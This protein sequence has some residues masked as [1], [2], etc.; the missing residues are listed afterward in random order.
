M[1]DEYYTQSGDTTALERK[2]M[3][4][5]KL[6]N[7]GEALKLLGRCWPRVINND[8][9]L[10]HYA[11]LLYIDGNKDSSS[12]VVQ[13]YISQFG[14]GPALEKLSSSILA[15]DVLSKMKDEYEVTPAPF[16]SEAGDYC[17]VYYGE[18]IMF[19]SHRKGKPDAWT[20]RHYSNIYITDTQSNLVFPVA[21]EMAAD[22]HNGAV[23]VADQQTIYFTTNSLV[24]GKLDD[25]NLHIAIAGR[26][27]QGVWVHS[28]LFPYSTPEYS[29][30]YPTF[31][32]DGQKII[33]CSDKP[34]GKGGFDLYQSERKEGKWDAPIH[35]KEIS[36]AGDDVFPFLAADGSLYFASDGYPGLGGLDIF[37][38]KLDEY[39]T[40]VPINFGAPI[41]S[42][43]DD[44]GLITRD[45]MNSGYIS[46]NRDNKEGIDKIYTFIKKKGNE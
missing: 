8:K 32:A 14:S 39:T 13:Q 12:I 42:S 38:V 33:F 36:T 34:G 7:P 30:A 19:T 9:L 20:G 1:Y 18:A 41:N 43:G 27:A 26:S 2:A 10:L 6:G 44:F 25:Y 11:E 15:Y 35:L 37:Q 29:V 3:C 4:Y 17:P 21:I 24:K 22:Y 28:G 40:A 45:G 23:A 31:S 46:S 5:I 16:N